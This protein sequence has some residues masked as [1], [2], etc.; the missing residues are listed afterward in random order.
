[1]INEPQPFLPF[2]NAVPQRQ[3]ESGN[4]SLTKGRNIFPNKTKHTKVLLIQ[5]DEFYQR[6]SPPPLLQFDWRMTHH[7]TTAVR[8]PVHGL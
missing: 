1:M 7:V 2:S 4:S 8:E 5:G 6:E 3:M